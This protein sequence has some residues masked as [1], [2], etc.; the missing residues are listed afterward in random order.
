MTDLE[1]AE[2]YWK[3]RDILQKIIESGERGPKE[4][5]LEALEE[6]LTEK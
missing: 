3:A 4:E 6:D 5:L 2:A 1:A